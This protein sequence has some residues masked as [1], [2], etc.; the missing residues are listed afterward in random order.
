[1]LSIFS[2]LWNDKVRDAV[3]HKTVYLK[4]TK[5]AATEGGTFTSGSWQIRDLNTLEGDTSFITV[6]SGFLLAT[7]DNNGG[8][9]D[10]AEQQFTLEAG[11]YEFEGQGTV[12]AVNTHRLKLYNVTDASDAII[13]Q[14]N[15]AGATDAGGSVARLVGTITITSSKTFDLRHRAQT[16]R[17]TDG[18]GQAIDFGVPETFSMLKIVQVKPG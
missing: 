15:F 2:K 10:T 16:S 6:P 1:M 17:S 3:A 8:T 12:Y 9:P 13:G 5:V 7:N 14:T 11:T 18:W 4:D